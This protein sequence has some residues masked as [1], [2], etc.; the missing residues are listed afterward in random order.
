MNILF[1]DNA[2]LVIDKPAGL[3]T[4]S[5]LAKHPSAERE[6]SD[7]LYKKQGGRPR[8]A[9][10]VRAVHRLDRPAGGLLVFAKSKTDLS[11]LMGQFER[12]EVEKI[13]RA[14]TTAAPPAATGKL[15]H[16]I[17]KDE[18]GRKALV[19]DQAAAGT[20]PCVLHYQLLET[21][22]SEFLLE[23]VLETGRFHQIRAQ[24]AHIG[25][26]IAGDVQYGAPQWQENAVKLQAC[27]LAFAHPRRGERLEFALET[28]ENW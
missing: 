4:E 16:F 18:S 22:G 14:Q 12:G 24:L 17:K 28:P 27:R 15:S 13:Y 19:F 2:L 5:G 8:H 7:Y 20:Q 11:A 9:P 21:R 25:C 26:A 23:I 6:L 3:S 1:E 10:Y